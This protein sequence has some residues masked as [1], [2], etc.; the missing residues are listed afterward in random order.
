MEATKQP[1]RII[2]AGDMA[3]RFGLA[4]GST[5]R[6]YLGSFVVDVSDLRKRQGLGRAMRIAASRIRECVCQ[7][8]RRVDVVSY[9]EPAMHERS[10][11]RLPQ[12]AM[13]SAL[14]WAGDELEATELRRF[15]PSAVKSKGA[16]HGRA[17]KGA[18]ID[19][20][21]RWTGK[22]IADDNEADAVLLLKVTMQ[23]L[24]AEQV[25]QENLF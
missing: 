15:W 18:M 9:E 10:A 17:D 8:T 13:V 22:H 25:R 14:V 11:N 19:A 7:V 5:T 23:E 4:I 3:L 2:L 24:Q 6:G 12:F 16:G 20:A 21:E 1:E